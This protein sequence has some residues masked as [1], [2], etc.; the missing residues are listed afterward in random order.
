MKRDENVEL[1]LVELVLNL[2]CETFLL[3]FRRFKTLKNYLI[4]DTPCSDILP[5]L[6]LMRLNHINFD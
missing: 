1:D 6:G 3:S 4:T 2:E 5:F